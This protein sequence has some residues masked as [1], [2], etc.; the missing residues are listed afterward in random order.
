VKLKILTFIAAMLILSTSAVAVDQGDVAPAWQAKTFDGQAVSFPELASG[1]P[2]VLLFWASWCD[3]CAAFMPYLKEI[4]EDYGADRIEIVAVNAKERDGDPDA[5]RAK[6]DF[7][8]VAIRGGDDIAA[9]YGV[10]FIPGLFVVNGDG[11]VSYRRGWTELP[12]GQ[13]VA[14]LWSEQVRA[15]LDAA[16]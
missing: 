7:P 4:Q 3:Y 2:V 16:L 11:T 8:I 14:Q 12:A 1:K 13:T 6:I 10:K 5:Y 15:A 9:A